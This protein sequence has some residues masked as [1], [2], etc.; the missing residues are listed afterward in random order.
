MRLVVTGTPGVGKTTIAR[1]L[2][3]RLKLKWINEKTF[4]QQRN[5]GKMDQKTGER[6]VPLGRLTAELNRFLKRHSSVVL[7]G[8]LLAEC[9]LRLIDWVIVVRLSPDRLDFRLRERHY[10]ETKI[11]DNVLCEGIDYCLKHAK[12]NYSPAKILEARNDKELKETISSIIKIVE[13]KTVQG[14]KK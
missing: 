6:V 7:D 13:K 12:R 2:A 3:K 4:A 11:Q 10:A 8:H 1:L 5:I 14:K 9:R